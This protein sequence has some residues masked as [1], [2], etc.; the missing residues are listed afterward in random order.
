MLQAVH[1][2]QQSLVG[3]SNSLADEV[4]DGLCGLVLLALGVVVEELELHVGEQAGAVVDLLDG[5]GQRP[6]DG[7]ALPVKTKAKLLIVERYFQNIWTC[8]A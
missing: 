8:L 6:G 3:K 7:T 2:T 5:V 4:D 1:I